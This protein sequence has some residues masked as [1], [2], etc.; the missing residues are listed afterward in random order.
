MGGERRGE[1]GQLRGLRPG[2]GGLD[3]P[4]RPAQARLHLCARARRGVNQARG[5]P[6]F[7][8]NSLTI[9]PCHEFVLFRPI[10]ISPGYYPP[11]LADLSFVLAALNV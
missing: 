3:H 6:G 5:L 1:P 11:L 2:E 7:V 9:C 10:C 4:P 8:E